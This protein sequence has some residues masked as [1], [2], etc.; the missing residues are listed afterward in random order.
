MERY[1]QRAWWPEYSALDQHVGLRHQ[2]RGPAEHD[3]SIQI[4]SPRRARRARAGGQQPG[5]IFEQASAHNRGGPTADPGG[6]FRFSQSSKLGSAKR[7]AHQFGIR[8]N[9]IAGEPASNHSAWNAVGFLITRIFCIAGGLLAAAS[10]DARVITT[11]IIK[12]RDGLERKGSLL[13]QG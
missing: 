12:E 8:T 13:E 5:F 9:Y 11:G 7:L 6:R 10:L 2:S 4:L 3:V 1:R